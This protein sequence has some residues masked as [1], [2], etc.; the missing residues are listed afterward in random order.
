MKNVI[1]TLALLSMSSAAFATPVP[2]I[3]GALSLQVLAMVGGLGLLL[4]K[5]RK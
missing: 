3:D 1:F 4:K 2:E 5:K